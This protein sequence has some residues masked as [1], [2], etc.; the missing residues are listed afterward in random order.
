MVSFFSN[1]TE[2]DTR[3][4]TLETKTQNQPGV[5]GITTFSGDVVSG[6]FKVSGQTGFLKANGN[7]DNTYLKI[8]LILKLVKIPKS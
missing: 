1:L 2:I 8:N 6:T 4:S 5:S 7:I 3:I